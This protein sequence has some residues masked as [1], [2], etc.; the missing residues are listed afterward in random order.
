MLVVY[1]VLWNNIDNRFLPP[2]WL[3]LSVLSITLLKNFY[4]KTLGNDEKAF[5]HWVWKFV[6]CN[7][8]IFLMQRKRKII[9]EAN[10]GNAFY[11]FEM[12]DFQGNAVSGH[13]MDIFSVNIFF[14]WEKEVALVCRENEMELCQ[15]LCM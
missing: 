5:V 2:I 10:G 7:I 13:L 4:L 1:F 3:F 6:F 14:Y 11:F 15:C 8:Y 12:E 9:S